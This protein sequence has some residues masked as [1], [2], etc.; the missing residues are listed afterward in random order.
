[1]FSDATTGSWSAGQWRKS[2][3]HGPCEAKY[4]DGSAYAGDMDKGQRHGNGVA[5]TGTTERYEGS[6]SLDERHGYGILLGGY[7]PFL[8]G[9]YKEN[10]PVG[11]H[12][13]WN[14]R[15]DTVL[16][17]MDSDDGA[18]TTTK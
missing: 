12:I 3:E 13:G 10:Q 18:V 9:R 4:A 8:F 11:V 6:W 17:N 16:L 1:V 14:M 5:S 7:W 15:S 2:G